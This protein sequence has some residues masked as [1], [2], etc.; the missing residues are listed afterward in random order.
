[1]S[2]FEMLLSE[3]LHHQGIASCLVYASWSYCSLQV[4]WVE[5]VQS[6]AE[7]YILFYLSV[8]LTGLILLALHYDATIAVYREGLLSWLICCPCPWSGFWG[9]K[10]RVRVGVHMKY[11]WYFFIYGTVGFH[12]LLESVGLCLLEHKIT[13]WF[14]VWIVLIRNVRQ[15]V[16]VSTN[17]Q[18]RANTDTRKYTMWNLRWGEPQVSFPPSSLSHIHTPIPASSWCFTWYTIIMIN[19]F[20]KRNQNKEMR[21]RLLSSWSFLLLF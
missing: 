12:F 14:L 11:V 10:Y 5:S 1:M 13:Y 16:S 3:K 20:K 6:S 17:D 8:N 4:F 9:I 18:A 19:D 15:S 7:T 2:A 21:R